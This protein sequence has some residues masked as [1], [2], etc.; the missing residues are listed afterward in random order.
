MARQCVRQTLWA[1]AAPLAAAALLVAPGAAG[2]SA[3]KAQ[4]PP[5]QPWTSTLPPSPGAGGNQFFGVSALSACDVW[6]VGNYQTVSGGPLLSLAEHWNG[7]AWKVVPTPN[8]GTSANFLRAV[9]AF[10]ASNVWAVGRADNSTLTLHWNGTSWSQ[11]PSPSPGVGGND[12]SGVDAVSATSA[13]AVGEASDASSTQKTLIL[14]WNGTNWSQVASPAP[15]TDSV[16]DAVTATSAGNAWA[17]GSFFTGTAGKTLILRW[18][19]TTWVQ[20]VSPN[21]SGPVTEMDLVG[22]AATSASNAWA[23]GT[24]NTGTS[25]KTFI[26]R[27]N[28]TAWKQV[29]SPNPDP[30]PSL[31]GVAAASASNAWAVGGAGSAGKTLILR[32][33]GTSWKQEASPSPGTG[34]SLTGVA[35]TSVSNVWA[36]GDFSNGGPSQVFAIH[37]C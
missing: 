2:T 15:G 23:V 3:A 1:L 35:A 10:S 5:C 21:P 20:A 4:A 26:A 29:S 34:S 37:C 16:L 24:Y 28:G 36:V 9:S 33:N 14:R 22:A 31:S 12:L 6:A 27:W 8:P 11:V 32:W 30:E 19:G 25:Q 13:W 7:T 18:N 17:V